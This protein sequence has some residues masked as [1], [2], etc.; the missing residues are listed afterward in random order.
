[1]SRFTSPSST[2]RIARSQLG[3][4]LSAYDEPFGDS[5]GPRD[6]S[7]L[8]SGCDQYKVALAG[9]GGDEVFAGYRKY[10]IVPMRRWLGRL[11]AARE[12]VARTLGCC[13]TAWIAPGPSPTFCASQ[14]RLAVRSGPSDAEAYVALTQLGTLAETASLIEGPTDG[15]RFVRAATEAFEAADGTPLQ[16]SMAADLWKPFAE[17]HAHQ[18]RIERVWPCS[19]EVRV[20]YLD[21]RLVELGWAYLSNMPSDVAAR[22]SFAHC[23]SGGL[24]ASY[25]GA[26]SRA[27]AFRSNLGFETSLDRRASSFSVGHGSSDSGFLRRLLFPRAATARFSLR[28]P[29]LVWHAFALAAWCE[30]TLG[31][32]RGRRSRRSFVRE[33]PTPRSNPRI[34]LLK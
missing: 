1:M 17:R 26:R 23:T 18:G 9:D 12:A 10:Q 11:P 34:P 21:H 25:L 31:D 33:T 3:D 13:R 14:V 20:P 24:G 29:I 27:L 19:L 4:V 30:G 2:R 7:A 16:R 6:L 8:A 28:A 15:S 5:S 22:W 32:G